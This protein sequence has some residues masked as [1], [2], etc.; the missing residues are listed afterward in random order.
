MAYTLCR[1]CGQPILRAGQRRASPDEYRHASGCPLD[2][3][4]CQHQRR[5]GRPC[6][7]SE[8]HRIHTTDNPQRHEFTADRSLTPYVEERR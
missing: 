2:D 6:F 4:T 1:E 3:Y 7:Q 8:Y 5:S